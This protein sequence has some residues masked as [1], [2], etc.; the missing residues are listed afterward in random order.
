M[1][2]TVQYA[3]FVVLEDT[4]RN[5][6]ILNLLYIFMHV[7]F[8]HFIAMPVLPILSG[9]LLDLRATYN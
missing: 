9:N 6:F 1:A 3:E 8:F 4:Q 5:G 2:L 7:L